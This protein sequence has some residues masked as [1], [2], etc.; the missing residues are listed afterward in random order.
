MVPG[1]KLDADLVGTAGMKID[2]DQSQVFFPFQHLIIQ[3][4]LFS[5]RI[6]FYGIGAMIFEQL[7]FKM[8]VIFQAVV[9][10]DREVLFFE[11]VFADLFGHPGCRFRRSG[12]DADTAYGTVEAMQ[13]TEVDIPGLV[14]FFF[15]VCFGDGKKIFVFGRIFLHRHVCRFF[16]DQQMIVFKDDFHLY[17]HVMPDKTIKVRWDEIQ[18]CTDPDVQREL[19]DIHLNTPELFTDYEEVEA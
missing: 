4:C 8:A 7:V 18:K 2:S 19:E 17:H 1:G 9:A 13:K 3:R 10:D 11:T 15:D 5:F 6:D 14:V 16:Y 12:E